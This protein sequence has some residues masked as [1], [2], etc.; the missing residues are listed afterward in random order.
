MQKLFLM[1]ALTA[2]CGSVLAAPNKVYQCTQRQHERLI[3]VSY[4]SPDTQVP[5]EVLYHKNGQTESLWRYNNE[6]GQCETQAENFLA[7]QQGWG[8]QCSSRDEAAVTDTD[9][10]NA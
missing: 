6:Q 10:S 8:W 2:A 5:C 1:L 3:D 4:A 7:K 9:D